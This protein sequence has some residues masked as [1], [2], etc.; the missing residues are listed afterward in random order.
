MLALATDFHSLEC[1]QEHFF[2]LSSNDRA[3]SVQEEYIHKFQ[4]QI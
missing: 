2:I 3:L 4:Q 1:C